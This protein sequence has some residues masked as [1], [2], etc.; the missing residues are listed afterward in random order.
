M[1]LPKMSTVAANLL[2]DIGYF[3][4]HVNLDLLKYNIRTEYSNEVLMA[5]ENSLNCSSDPDEMIRKDFTSLKIYAIH[6]GEADETTTQELREYKHYYKK[7]KDHE[8][9]RPSLVIGH[10]ANF[11]LLE[12]EVW[13]NEIASDDY[14]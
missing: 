6:V 11:I 12:P 4:V 9:Y 2:I 8:N 7:V 5:A 3:P 1:G 14:K 13:E 10:Q